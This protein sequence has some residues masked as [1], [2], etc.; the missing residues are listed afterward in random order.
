MSLRRYNTGNS[1]GRAEG[2]SGYR[3]GVF[4]AVAAVAGEEGRRWVE[5]GRSGGV[6]QSR[7]EDEVVSRRCTQC[8]RGGGGGPAAG[9]EGGRRKNRFN[10]S[11]NVKTGGFS[12]L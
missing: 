11:S 10:E 6:G 9:K 4:G 5:G 3:I 1:G 2:R 7:M 12:R 8:S